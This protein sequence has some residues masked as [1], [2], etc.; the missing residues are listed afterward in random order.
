M[1]SSISSSTE[2]SVWVKD[3]ESKRIDTF[4]SVLFSDF[5]RSYIQRLIDRG[6]VWINGIA[7]KKNTKIYRGN[8]IRVDWRIDKMRFEAEEMHLDVVFENEDF[9]IIN[10]DA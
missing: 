9:A 2:F 5:S 4:L 1:N 7:I 3:R 6:D 8:V 10:K